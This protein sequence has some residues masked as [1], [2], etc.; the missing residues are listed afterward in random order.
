MND[1]VITDIAEKLKKAD[2][3]K[4]ILFGSYA[5]GLPNENSD[6]DILLVTKDNYIPK[7]YSEKSKLVIEITNLIKKEKSEVPIDLIIHTIPMHQRFIDLN[8]GFAREIKEKGKI[9]YERDN[10]TMA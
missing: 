5:Y 10:T 1:S 9:L 8:S 2:P 7:S 4:I 6:I 3:E